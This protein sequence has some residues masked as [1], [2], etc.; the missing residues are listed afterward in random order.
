[1][2]YQ[3]FYSFERFIWVQ[4]DIFELF[5]LYSI[6]VLVSMSSENRK[7]MFTYFPNML[8]LQYHAN[9][10]FDW[11][12][13]RTSTSVWTSKLR[14]E[15]ALTS[16]RCFSESWRKSIPNK[17]VIFYVWIIIEGISTPNVIYKPHYG[18]VTLPK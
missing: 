2:S 3:N 17:L 15:I 5:P 4:F 8:T 9:S 13:W 11:T 10:W 18:P 1:M 16:V 12:T 7:K 6:Y 14:R